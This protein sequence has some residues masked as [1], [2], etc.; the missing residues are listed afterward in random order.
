LIKT[1]ARAMW[2]RVGTSMKYSV[3]DRPML[4]AILIAF[5]LGP[6]WITSR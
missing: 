5:V 6:G 1:Q 3:G 2:P 4:F